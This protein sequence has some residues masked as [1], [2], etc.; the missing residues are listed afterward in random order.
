M[1]THVVNIGTEN[2]D[3]IKDRLHPRVMAA[4]GLPSTFALD[5]QTG[6]L[7]VGFIADLT[8][9]QITV[10][11]ELARAA[12]T[13]LTRAERNAIQSDIDLLV[14]FQGVATPTLAQTA[15]AVKAQSRILRAMLRS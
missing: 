9:P 4:F 11:T 2:Q 7:T 13:G 15:A 3:E 10:L 1:S 8:A 6:D 12:K 5:P 14:A